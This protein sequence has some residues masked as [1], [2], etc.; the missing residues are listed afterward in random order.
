MN[1]AELIQGMKRAAL[2]AG[3]FI[4]Q[5]REIFQSNQ[6]ESKAK[7]DLISYVDRESEKMLVEALKIIL[8]SAGFIA[9]ENTESIIKDS[10]WIIDPLDG[11]TNFVHGIPC[12][13]VSVA[14]EQKGE[15]S[16]GVVYEVSRDEL[17][18]AIKG[19]GA[20]LNDSVIKVSTSKIFEESLIATG[21]P[22]NDFSKQSQY[23]TALEFLMRNTRGVRRIGAAAADLCYLAC[24]RFDAFF[25]YNLKP[26]DVAAGSLIASE[27][28]AIIQD[29]NGG[30]NY[31]FGKEIM[32]A[33]PS[34]F[35]HFGKF[36]QNT[37]NEY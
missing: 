30:S 12:Y 5:Q 19:G 13:A 9:E 25:E 31:I 26:W 17:F 28:G 11:T 23:L 16:A 34:F 14:L 33:N 36:I 2:E 20:F 29:F 22:V 21:F 37:F 3:H 24:G 4:A 10:N 27:A 18:F 15:I 35:Q 7:N 1:A 6:A 8:P 32:A